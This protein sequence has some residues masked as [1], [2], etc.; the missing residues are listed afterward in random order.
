MRDSGAGMP[1]EF[2]QADDFL[3]RG[4]FGPVQ[5]QRFLDLVADAKNRIQRGAGVL[6][7]VTDHAAAD[8]LEFAARTF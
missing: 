7:N 6:E 2:Q 8:L 3:I 4:F 1:D 5:F